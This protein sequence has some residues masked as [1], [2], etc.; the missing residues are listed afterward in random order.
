ML[1][2]LLYAEMRSRIEARETEVS[3]A[4]GEKGRSQVLPLLVTAGVVRAGDKVLLA[5]RKGGH[6]AGKWEF[7]GG[8][9]EPGEAP[10]EGL[11]RELLEELGLEVEV[12]DVCAVVYHVYETGPVLLLAY[13]CTPKEEKELPPEARWVEAAELFRFDLAPADRRIA[14]KFLER[15]FS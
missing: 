1:S 11:K 8:K 13:F 6:L 15:K 10:E 7:P 5:R 3:A 2:K 12:G 14:A 9:L 4:A